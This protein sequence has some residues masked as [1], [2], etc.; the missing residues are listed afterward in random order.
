MRETPPASRAAIV[1]LSG[2]S[3]LPEERDLLRETPPLGVIL[4]KRNV[5][6]PDR[7]AA[8]IGALR[9]IVPDM[10]LCV[11]QE[12]GRVARLRPPFWDAH[13]PAAA[14]GALYAREPK[15]GLRAAFLCGALIGAQC[16]DAGFDLVCAPVLDL[17][18]PG[19]DAVIGDRAFSADPEAVSVLGAAFA[20]GLLAA[21]IQPVGKHAPGHGRSLVDSHLALPELDGLDENDLLPFRANRNLP[22]MMTAHIRYRA[23]DPD[24]PATLSRTVI[25]E[26]L[27]RE[28]GFTGLI[29]SDDLSMHAVSGEPGALAASALAAGCDLALHCSGVLAETRSVLAASPPPDAALRARLEAATALASARKQTLDRAALAAERARLLSW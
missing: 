23:L 26:V 18:V 4:F 13:P 25:D 7:L 2:P 15:A 22:W 16:A 9:D 20:D 19:A 17:Y 6:T 27:R 12:G 14:L 24:R 11:D 29:V 5:D 21:G 1:G 10:L 8:L 28:L 3:L